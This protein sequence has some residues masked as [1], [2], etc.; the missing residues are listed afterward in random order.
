MATN[1]SPYT[2]STL[3]RFV[4]SFHRTM[5]ILVLVLMLLL[6]AWSRLYLFSCAA[7]LWKAGEQFL[8]S[9]LHL[10]CRCSVGLGSG[11]A[12]QFLDCYIRLEISG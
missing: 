2:A 9:G 8:L 1:G 3:V 7:P 10:H 5:L 12:I 11:C 4:F 6:T